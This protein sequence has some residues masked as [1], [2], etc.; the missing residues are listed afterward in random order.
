VNQE[1]KKER[2]KILLATEWYYP[3]VNGVVISVANL[4][5][6]LRE[7]GHDVRIMTLSPRFF[8]LHK[9]NIYYI[10]SVKAERLYPGGR[11]SFPAYF[12]HYEELTLWSPDVVH[13][14]AEFTTFFLARRLAATHDIPQI[15]TY[16]TMYEDYTHY[17]TSRP[18][19]GRKTIEFLSRKLLHDMDRVIVPTEKVKKVLEGYGIATPMEVVP[20]GID[21]L[22][23][24]TK[25][26]EER[27]MELRKQW[28]IT[29]ETKVLLYVGRMAKEKNIDE[30]IKYFSK[31]HERNWVLLLVGDG[32]YRTE[33]VNLV[34]QMGLQNRIRFTGMVPPEQVAAYYHMGHVFVNSSTSETQGLTYVEA[35]AAGLPCVCRRDPLMEDLVVNGVTGFDFEDFQKFDSS[36]KRL[37]SSDREREVL[38]QNAK[39][40]AAGY[41]IDRFGERMEQVYRTVM[42]EHGLGKEK[43]RRLLIPVHR[44]LP[45]WPSLIKNPYKSNSKIL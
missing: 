19:V 3:L 45:P 44:K 26:D 17:F 22:R 30:L 21:L 20:T 35:L 31:I 33:L 8:P 12:P 4:S 5:R 23:F 29:P 37:L 38:S 27:L 41:S 39:D 15:H 6:A 14:H 9:D 40:K 2:L 28:E 24:T 34:N 16:H 18:E 42:A 32:P 43:K 36:L 25:P 7:R 11:A 1:G 10:G 13:T